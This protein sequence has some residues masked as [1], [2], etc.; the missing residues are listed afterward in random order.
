MQIF[1]N[2]LYN[3]LK[4][5]NI[6]QR[7]LAEMAHTTEATISRYLSD[8]RRMPRADLIISIAEAL[9]VS[10]DY[11]LGLTS[12]PNRGSLSPE[13]EEL[14]YYYSNASES[15]RKVIWAV[16][17]KYRDSDIQIAASGQDKWNSTDSSLRQQAV[18]KFEGNNV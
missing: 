2:I 17:D 5:R 11:L 14:I 12:V 15:D 18:K 1:S 3:L 10:T 4:Q 8:A 16:L 6:T 9:N 7:M 13:T